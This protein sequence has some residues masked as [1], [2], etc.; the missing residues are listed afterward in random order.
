MFGLQHKVTIEV[1]T[2]AVLVL[3]ALRVML[4]QFQK[5]KPPSEQGDKHEYH[6]LQQE[7]LP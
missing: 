5:L 7:K 4:G 3:N 1:A 6:H 2:S